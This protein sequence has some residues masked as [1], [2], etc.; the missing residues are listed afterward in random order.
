[1]TIAGVAGIVGGT[2]GLF[3]KHQE[4]SMASGGDAR[5]GGRMRKAQWS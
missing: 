5:M 3:K 1:M 4:G 2:K